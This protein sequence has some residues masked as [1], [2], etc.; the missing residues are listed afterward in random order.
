MKTKGGIELNRKT[1]LKILFFIA[2]PSCLISVVLA[3]I[4]ISR[5]SDSM[6]LL[7][8]LMLYASALTSGMTA[9]MLDEI[10][11]LGGD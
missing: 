11:P 7:G 9:G 4:G 1:K 6:I 10:K 8:L 3:L 5:Q 2:T